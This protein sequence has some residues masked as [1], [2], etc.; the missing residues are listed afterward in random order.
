MVVAPITT[1]I[2]K[3]LQTMKTDPPPNISAAP[4]QIHHQI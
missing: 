3:E 1:S 4:K 2:L